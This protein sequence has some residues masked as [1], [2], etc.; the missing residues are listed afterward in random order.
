MRPTI[1]RIG[2]LGTGALIALGLFAAAPAGASGSAGPGVNSPDSTRFPARGPT[3]GPAHSDPPRVSNRGAAQP[4]RPWPGA[5]PPA[6]GPGAPGTPPDGP[7]PT[8]ATAPP[9]ATASTTA[10]G[11]EVLGQQISR[12]AALARTGA[13]VG[14]LTLLGL[15]LGGSGRLTVL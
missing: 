15:V 5:P 2:A 1:A 4:R 13:G 14:V 3:P 12:P 9:A 10:P 11:T 6:L 7:A 8:D